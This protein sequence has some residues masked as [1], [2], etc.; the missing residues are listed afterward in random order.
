ME[1]DLR[2]PSVARRRA[3]MTADT[4]FGGSETTTNALSAD[5]MLLAQNPDCFALLKSDPDGVTIPKGTVV[6]VR[7]AA[8]NRDPARFAEPDRI[9][10]TRKN[11]ASHLGFGSGVHHCLGAPLAR[12][13]LWWGFTAFLDRIEE[14]RLAP[15]K[16]QLRHV[17]HFYLRCLQE[18]HIEI[19]ARRCPQV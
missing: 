17:P 14:F 18:L 1:C 9:D 6:N 5:I 19:T 11:A 2:T 10:L 16:N 8:A 15:G 7:Y 4:F 13:E 3:E 12:R